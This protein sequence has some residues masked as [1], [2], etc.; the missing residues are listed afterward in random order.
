MEI[1]RIADASRLPCLFEIE[2]GDL[3]QRVHAG[4]GSPRAAHA[5]RFAR[6]F[7]DRRFERALNRYAFSLALPADEGRAVIF[8]GDAV[9]GHSGP[10]RSVGT[11]H[12]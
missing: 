8:D 4:V 3:P 1:H 2:V 12:P 9:A 5:R 10:V 6:E 7:T 11:R